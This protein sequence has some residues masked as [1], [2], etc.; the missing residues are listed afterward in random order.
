MENAAPD[1]T[2][3]DR[4]LELVGAGDREAFDA[5]FARYRQYLR[6]VVALR[7]DP[8]LRPRLDPS[9]VVQETQMEAFRRLSDYLERRP[10]SFHLWLRKMACE[11]A[12]MAQREHLR[13]AR[14]SL[15][16][17]VALPDR[18]SFQLAEQFL[19][20]G[21]TPSQRL[22]RSELAHRVAEVMKRLTVSD[23]DLLMM[24][25]LEGLSN[26]EAA[27]VLQIEPAA[28]SQRYG[29]AVL[30]LRKLMIAGGLLESRP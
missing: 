13:A 29:R 21:S 28:A 27:E 1:S 11:R 2:G 25:N 19:A 20:K 15:A 10:M 12:M 3:T 24:R 16:R 6:Q 8:K 4:L 17:E 23:R 30:R 22:D 7:L 14:R 18:S 5:L 9:D 26:Q